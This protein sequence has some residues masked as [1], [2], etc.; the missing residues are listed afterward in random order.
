MELQE[1]GRSDRDRVVS[2]FDEDPALLVSPHSVRKALRSRPL[3]VTLTHV[4]D[5]MI[6]W[7]RVH[8]IDALRSLLTKSDAC[9]A[10]T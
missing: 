5:L 8:A 1:S 9:R 10:S 4:L 6:A 3:K 7:T 2:A